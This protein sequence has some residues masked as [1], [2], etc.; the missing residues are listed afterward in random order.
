[1]KKF[2]LYLPLAISYAVIIWML[3]SFIEINIK[4]YE[5]NPQYCPFNIFELGL[6]YI[7]PILY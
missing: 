1:M 4:S 7:K 6:K 5:P 3:L 2:L